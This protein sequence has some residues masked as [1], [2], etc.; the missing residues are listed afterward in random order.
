[1]RVLILVMIVSGCQ[2][3]RPY[4]KEF[5]LSPLS[6]NQAGGEDFIGS[7]ERLRSGQTFQTGSSCPTCG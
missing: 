7:K 3:V 6:S 1:M 4:E 2:T 5:F